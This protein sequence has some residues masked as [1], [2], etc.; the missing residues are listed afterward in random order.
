MKAVLAGKRQVEVA[1]VFGVTRQAVG[2]WIKL[3]REGGY[4]ALKAKPRSKM[5][6][7]YCSP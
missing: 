4:K 3:Y 1:N 7:I 2:K 6:T 5:Q